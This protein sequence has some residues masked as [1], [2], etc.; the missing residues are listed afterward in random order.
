MKYNVALIP[1]RPA[2][3]KLY[4]QSAQRNFGNRYSQY[5]LGRD[6]IPHITLCQFDDA[7]EFDEKK[8]TS[9]GA[10]RKIIKQLKTQFVDH[11]FHPTFIGIHFLKLSSQFGELFSSD[12]FSV[13]LLVQ[14]ERKLVS[15][16]ENVS[17]MVVE[18]G[19]RV[20]NTLG[21]AYRPHLTLASLSAVATLSI[22]SF[23][24]DLLGTPSFPF[25]V[26]LGLSDDYW[27]FAKVIDE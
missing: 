12:L 24:H 16:H 11:V 18:L 26:R 25:V 9:Q 4:I 2:F 6:S 15:L 17:S 19:F 1:A 7:N 21:E 23:P 14:R 5:L 22:P 27:Q 13:E 10:L 20:L 8:G 3:Y